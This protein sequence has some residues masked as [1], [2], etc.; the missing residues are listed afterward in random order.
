MYI[1][2]IGW[3]SKAIDKVVVGTILPFLC[4]L[5]TCIVIGTVVQMQHYPRHSMDNST[6]VDTV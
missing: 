2:L 4:R 6:A 1:T 5:F 3:Y